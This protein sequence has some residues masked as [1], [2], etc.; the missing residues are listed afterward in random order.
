M[1][2]SKRLAQIQ[3]QAY[4]EEIIQSD[5]SEG[6]KL[7]QAYDYIVERYVESTLREIELARAMKDQETVIREQIKMETIKF[8]GETLHEIHRI[9]N[10]RLPS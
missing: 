8:S 10:R 2:P 3:W 5:L 9:I 4:I 6:E 7:L 1:D